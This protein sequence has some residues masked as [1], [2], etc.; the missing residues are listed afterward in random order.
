MRVA[1]SRPFVFTFFLE[2]W[3]Q[4][5]N[6]QAA[7]VFS[8]LSE[9]SKERE[10]AKFLINPSPVAEKETNFRRAFSDEDSWFAEFI[11]G[12]NHLRN[13]SR[14]DAIEAYKRSDKA[15]R[16]ASQDGILGADG[17]LVEQVKRRLEE[18]DTVDEPPEKS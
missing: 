8:F 16:Q 14:K 15:A 10:A 11:I 12:E 4:S 7:F 6:Q 3:R 18:L 13:G 17:M 1:L 9:G 5:R 2:A